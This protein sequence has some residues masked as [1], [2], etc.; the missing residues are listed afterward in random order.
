MGGARAEM[1]AGAAAMAPML[2][3]VIPF[4][5][6]AGTTPAA[7]GMDWEAALGFSIILFAGASQLAAIDVLSRDGSAL[8]AAVV[9]W[10]INLRMLLYSA[11]LAPYLAHE[12]FR[13]RLGASYLMVDQNY[14]LCVT[15]WAEGK[16]DPKGRAWFFIGGGLLLW[17]AWQLAT[18]AG[19]LLGE[20][21]PDELPLDFAVPLVFLVLLI[22][23]INSRPAAVSAVVGGAATVATLELGAG[24]LSI[25]CGA[26]AGIIGGVV[27][28]I[29][30]HRRA[31][32]GPPEPLEDLG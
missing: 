10:T 24:S 4:G 31:P 27:T 8:L 17:S 5:L 6:V 28:E 32:S 18:L 12:S 25:V 13:K 16:G 2:I 7:V 29:V 22:P 19:A 15:R 3:G 20:T 21:L 14:A 1:R 11:S 9:A 26:V 30:L 23:A